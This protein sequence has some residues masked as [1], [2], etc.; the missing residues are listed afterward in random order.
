M[1]KYKLRAEGINDVLQFL[2]NQQEMGI[3][4]AKIKTRSVVP[5][6]EVT[7]KSEMELDQIKTFLESIPDGHVMVDTVALEKDYTGIR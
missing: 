4:S 7:F 2:Y 6:V 1:K 3:H 5:D